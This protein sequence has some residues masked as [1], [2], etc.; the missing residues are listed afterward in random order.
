MDTRRITGNLLK[1]NIELIGIKGTAIRGMDFIASRFGELWRIRRYCDRHLAPAM[2]S[3]AVPV[4]K[5]RTDLDGSSTIWVCW[6]QGMEEAPE[7]VKMCY[8]SLKKYNG[9][10]DICVLTD[11]N[12]G[13][14]VKF[15]SY[16][17]RKYQEGKI[18]RPHYSDMLR[19]AILYCYGGIWVDATMLFVESIPQFIWDSDLF[20]FKF[21]PQGAR[22]QAC[23]SQF[24]RGGVGNEI[25]RRTL[26]GLFKFW[27]NHDKLISYYLFHYVLGCA[28]DSDSKLQQ[29]FN[30][31]PLLPA[32]D[33]H[34]LQWRFFEHYTDLEWDLIKRTSFVHKLSYKHMEGA[35][36]ED[37]F[38]KHIVE[39]YND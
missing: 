36:K 18:K 7:L 5:L 9:D 38:Y 8:K 2:K 10:H 31:I 21:D 25:L 37:T 11:E 12:I 26:M 19:A 32:V 28:V 35:D 39:M 4:K 33:N 20:A 13:S 6:F 22:Y 17:E 15:P 29:E 16:I 1:E 23:S 14:Y 3:D 30:E 27:K 34:V 24:I